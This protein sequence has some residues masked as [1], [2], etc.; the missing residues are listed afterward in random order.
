MD[1]IHT[2]HHTSQ[3]YPYLPTLSFYSLNIIVAYKHSNRNKNNLVY[4][5]LFTRI[6]ANHL[7]PGNQLGTHI[8]GRLNLA[9]SLIINCLLF[10]F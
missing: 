3:I 2:L 1:H 4:L 7:V 10:L 8:W 5:A 9:F 6:D